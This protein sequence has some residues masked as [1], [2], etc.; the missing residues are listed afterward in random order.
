MLVHREARAQRSAACIAI[1]ALR[2]HGRQRSRGDRAAEERHR[3]QRDGLCQSERGDRTRGDHR[4]E[5]QVHEA[6][7]LQYTAA[8]QRR[9]EVA[10]HRPYRRILE[11]RRQRQPAQQRE[12]G[13]QLYQELQRTA[14]HRAPRH[15]SCRIL[16]A[17]A[18][19]EEHCRDDRQ[20]PHHGRHVR[21]EESSVA[22]QHA[23]APRRE[24]QQP[25]TRK[26]DAHERR[27]ERASRRREARREQCHQLRGPDD[28]DQHQRRRQQRQQREHRTGNA[29]R[30]RV[31]P[32]GAQARVHRDERRGQ[33]A[34]TE[35]VLQQVRDAQR[36]TQCAAS[37]RSPEHMRDHG[38]ARKT[39]HATDQ[40]PCR[41]QRG[42]RS[43][44]KLA[45]GCR[46][47]SRRHAPA[48]PRPCHTPAAIA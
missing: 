15:Q 34:F 3:Q 35:E 20:V 17:R 26:H 18:T 27:G 1:A 8:H 23:Q 33:R 6:A 16:Q 9:G 37:H 10:R 32:F 36:G 43:A 38:V 29:H 30:F 5:L 47:V 28:A 42:T 46:V 2:R 45:D 31:A 25:H 22:V 11:C 24:H 21:Q 4:G 14:D 7:H 12:H 19:A 40:D 48:R 44:R 41:D 13:R 39:E